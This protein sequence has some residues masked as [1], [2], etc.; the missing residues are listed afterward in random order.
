MSS[1]SSLSTPAI[2][3]AGTAMRESERAENSVPNLGAI[4]KA[5]PKITGGS[6]STQPDVCISEVD[7]PWMYNKA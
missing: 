1:S 4:E 2:R 7:D 5:S 3:P 6:V